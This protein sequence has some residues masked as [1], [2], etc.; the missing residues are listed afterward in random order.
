MAMSATLKAFLT[1]AKVKYKSQKHPVAYT[2]QEIAAAQHVPGKQLVKCVLV[3]TDK[4][5]A[6]AVLPAIH[7]VDLAKLKTLLKAKKLSIAKEA[8]IKK[9]FPDL[10]IGAMSPFG[11]LY[12][13]P[14][15]VDK[16]LASAEE[17][18]CN[19]GTHTETIKLRYRDFEK[20]VK[21]RAGNFGL[22]ISKARKPKS[23]R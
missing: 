23:K 14:V 5:Y 3:Q 8:D 12:N 1:K 21:P 6:L 4:G 2:A 11:N 22:H 18:V 19:A 20:L 15:V 9:T 17:I 7:L 13:I 10:E 16:T